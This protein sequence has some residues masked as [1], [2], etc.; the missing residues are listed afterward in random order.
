[1]NSAASAQAFGWQPQAV[2]RAIYRPFDRQYHF[3]DKK[4]NDRPRPDLQ[5]AWGNSN[6]C[7]YSMPGGTGAG[8]ATWC[9]GL[10][11][12]YHAFR[13]SYGGYA[14]PLWDR[15]V[16][17]DAHNLNPALLAGLRAACAAH[18]S[19]QQVFDCILCLLSAKSY[20]L[21][22]AEDLEDVFPHIPFPAQ[23]AVFLEAA[24]LGAEIRAVETFARPPGADFLPANLCRFVTQPQG[25]IISPSYDDG[26]FELCEKGAGKVTGIPA[27]I[28]HFSVSGY[29]LLPRW[30]N[31]R[32]G[33][34]VDYP[35]ATELRDI[36]GRIAEMIDL[37]AKADKIMA[38]TLK[39]V[40]GRGT[41]GFGPALE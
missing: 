28:W 38:E 14:F 33:L 34:E 37:C 8:P 16:G 13:G 25:K 6:V 5:N 41:I 12:D 35:L 1:M 27:E 26:G 39:Q 40:L 10:L 32:A 7:L 30:I 4:F 18:I 29:E 17:P 36:C 22:F 9:H 15:R 24:S 11:P 21:T 23:Y 20:T 2:V 3:A 31:G 19:A